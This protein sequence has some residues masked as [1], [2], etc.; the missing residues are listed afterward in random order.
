MTAI[1]TQPQLSELAAAVRGVVDPDA[2][3]GETA[4]L[5]AEQLRRHLPTPEVLRT[6]ASSRLAARYRENGSIAARH[7]PRLSPDGAF[8][9]IRSWVLGDP[10][11]GDAAIPTDS[12]ADLVRGS[13]SSLRGVEGANEDLFDA[14]LNLNR[15][16]TK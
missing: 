14:D 5:V 12:T 1:E 10:C 4:E 13:A 2:R 8:S 7:A 16:E 9:I 3:W 11:Q 15:Q 6:A